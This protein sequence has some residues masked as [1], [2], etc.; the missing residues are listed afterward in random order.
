[1][2][3]RYNGFSNLNNYARKAQRVPRGQSAAF[4]G[5]PAGALGIVPED[6]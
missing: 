3:V 4:I 5:E 2:D 6:E 1:M